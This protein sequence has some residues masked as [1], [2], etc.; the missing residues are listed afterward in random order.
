MFVHKVVVGGA[1]LDFCAKVEENEIKVGSVS[2]CCEPN[3]FSFVTLVLYRLQ[4]LLPAYPANQGISHIFYGAD[5]AFQ[6]F[7]FLQCSYTVCDLCLQTLLFGYRLVYSFLCSL[8]LCPSRCLEL[9]T[10]ESCIRVLEEWA[11]TLPTA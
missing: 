1:V 10:Q 7:V 2:A 9:L 8:C 5:L 4:C 6:C 3:K 11:T